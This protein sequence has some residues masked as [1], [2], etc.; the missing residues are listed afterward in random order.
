MLVDVVSRKFSFGFA[1][2]FS[3][4][5]SELNIMGEGEPFLQNV[6]EEASNV[7]IGSD[8]WPSGLT[9]AFNTAVHESTKCTPDRLFL[10]REMKCHLVVRWN[11]F[12]ES[13][14]DL[15]DANQSFWT[16]VYRTRGG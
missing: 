13:A 8:Y 3:G 11:L 2:G 15:W 16:Q 7:V 9:M 12:P 1:P 5:F 10:G 14:G 6:R 4:A